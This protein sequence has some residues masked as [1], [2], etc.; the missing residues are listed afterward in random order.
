MSEPPVDRNT[1]L[2]LRRTD[3]AL[4]RS[5][6]AAERTLMAW[7][8]TALSMIGFGFTIGK[9]GQ[10]LETGAFKGLLGLREFSFRGLGYLLVSIG[11]LA[12]L[13]AAAQYRRRLRA[14]AEGGERVEWSSAFWIALL[15]GMLGFFAFGALALRF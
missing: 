7:I 13:L 6:W 2:A 15:L 1:A 10:A 5:S 3:L 14:L 9:L 8:R 4:R 11:T 12:L